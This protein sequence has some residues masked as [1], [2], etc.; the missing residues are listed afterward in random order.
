MPDFTADSNILTPAP[1]P[2]FPEMWTWTILQ[3]LY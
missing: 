3:I 2:A 1:F